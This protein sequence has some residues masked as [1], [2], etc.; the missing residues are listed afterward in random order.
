ML[1]SVE[2]AMSITNWWDNIIPEE[3]A[4]A[5]AI[6]EVYIGRGEADVD[7]PRD[8]TMLAKAVAFQTVYMKQH[9][10]MIYE[11]VAVKNITV[12]GSSYTFREGDD[13][14]PYIAPLARMACAKLSWTRSRTVNTG[15][16]TAPGAK[17]LDW[18]TED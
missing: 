16:M 2:E 17:L 6:I 7:N 18:W 3:I 10:N 4:Q 12:G 5:Q 9:G 14:S 8:L 11:Q 15:R 1:V 13:V